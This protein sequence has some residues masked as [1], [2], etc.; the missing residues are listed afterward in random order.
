MLPENGSR[1]HTGLQKLAVPIHTRQEGAAR[2]RVGGDESSTRVQIIGRTWNCV[3]S[4]RFRSQAVEVFIKENLF[5][6]GP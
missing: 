3:L 1:P 2:V 5:S 6:C 4:H